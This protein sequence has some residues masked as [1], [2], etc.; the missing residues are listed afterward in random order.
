MKAQI[1]SQ[2]KNEVDEL[3]SLCVVSPLEEHIQNALHKSEETLGEAVAEKAQ[4]TERHLSGQ[5]GAL[6][7]LLEE[8]TRELS[9]WLDTD[10]PE[11][12][13]DSGKA[14]H[15]DIS[16]LAGALDKRLT[17][18]EQLL[19]DAKQDL[20][21]ASQ[22]NAGAFLEELTSASQSIGQSIRASTDA[23]EQDI[24]QLSA[25]LAAHKA[26][27]GTLM[28]QM[29]GG[30]SRSSQAVEKTLA[31]ITR[32]IDNRFSELFHDREQARAELGQQIDDKLSELWQTTLRKLEQLKSTEES[33]LIETGNKVDNL[34]EALERIQACVANRQDE[35][36]TELEQ[37]KSKAEEQT[38]KRYKT[39]LA[40]SL[41][42][43]SA[44]FLGI[45][46]L[47]LICFL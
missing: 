20:T 15:E 11:T 21:D 7:T 45:I 14:V 39:L 29:D 22:R 34:A 35:L 46:A 6:R 40:V 44:N 5:I 17:A 13:E 24:E 1:K 26:Q 28:Q 3:L 18:L 32:E 4:L 12:I 23:A 25:E 31:E 41:L 10:I 2:A 30:F 36:K 43:G 19:L 37:Y 27:I 38:E 8:R 33:N 42:L 16:G 9:E 47:A